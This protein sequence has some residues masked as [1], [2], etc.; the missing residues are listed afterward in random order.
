M[1]RSLVGER[2]LQARRPGALGLLEQPIEHLQVIVEGVDLQALVAGE[3]EGVVGGLLELG[4]VEPRTSV[5]TL[6][7]RTPKG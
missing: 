7:T 5:V 4:G 1:E 2:R 3:E 6:K